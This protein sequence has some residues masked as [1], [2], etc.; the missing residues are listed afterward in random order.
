[1]IYDNHVDNMLCVYFIKYC[2][3]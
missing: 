1:M 3:Y 2:Y